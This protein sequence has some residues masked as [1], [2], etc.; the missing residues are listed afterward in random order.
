M[1]SKEMQLSVCIIAKNEEKNIE[2]CLKSLVSYDVEIVVVDTGSTDCTKEIASQYT[3]AVY[4]FTWCDDF[5]TAKNFAVSKATNAYVMIL[6]SDE[7]IESFDKDGVMRLLCQNAGSVG[8]I[9]RRNILSKNGKQH[10]GN[11]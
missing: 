2:R 1:D 9:R 11:L 8:R 4:D 7:F 5:A 6:D 10:L 3:S